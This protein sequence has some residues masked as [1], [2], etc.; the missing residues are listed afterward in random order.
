L[1]AAESERLQALLDV[2]RREGLAPAA[3]PAEES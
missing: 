1:V 2:A 3:A